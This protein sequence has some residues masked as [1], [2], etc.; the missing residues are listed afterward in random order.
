M[1]AAAASGEP[2]GRQVGGHWRFARSAALAWL[3]ADGAG[4]P[5]ES[6]APRRS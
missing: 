4:D 5:Q 1:L 6:A 2:P 3:V